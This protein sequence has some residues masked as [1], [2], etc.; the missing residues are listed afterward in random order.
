MKTDEMP[1][2]NIGFYCNSCSKNIYDLTNK[3]DKEVTQIL[4]SDNRNICIHI[5][6][7]R[8]HLV[9]SKSFGWKFLLV[10]L[11]NMKTI[12]FNKLYG[13]TNSVNSIKKQ[14]KTISRVI[15][16][17]V[18][19]SKTGTNIRLPLIEVV[20][21]GVTI[22]LKKG[23][24]Q[25]K[26]EFVIENSP[27]DGDTISIRINSGGYVGK[28]I[29][30][31]TIKKTITT[32]NTSIPKSGE[33]PYFKNEFGSE[34]QDITWTGAVCIRPRIDTIKPKTR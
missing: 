20:K 11:L 6:K 9:S 26:F 1:K 22:V 25:G 32:L 33:I 30:N 14:Q 31:F 28:I 8:L 24:I 4:N 2:S 15:K 19:D 23:D 27:F 29:E 3:T 12:F 16:G 34:H 7:K 18:T 10:M 17:Q 21:N 13:Q 5:Q